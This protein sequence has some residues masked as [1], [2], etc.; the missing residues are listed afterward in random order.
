VLTM[1]VFTMLPEVVAL[2]DSGL[3]AEV[4]FL[5]GERHGIQDI[6][7]SCRL[8]EVALVLY[9]SC[10][11]PEERS[12]NLRL[13]NPQGRVREDGIQPDLILQQFFSA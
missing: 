10:M 3:E 2:I 9:P 11:E 7:S 13:M 12:I 5:D 1:I 6:S 4:Y 8:L